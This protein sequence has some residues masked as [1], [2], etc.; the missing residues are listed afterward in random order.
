MQIV[1]FSGIVLSLF[2]LILSTADGR[3]D[4]FYLRFTSNKQKSLILGTSR[5]A[6]G[7][8]P[9]IIDSL[10]GTKMYNYSFTVA[11]SPYGEVYFES[12]KKKIDK[13]SREGVFIITVDPWSI[14]SATVDPNDEKNFRENDKCLDNTKWVN[15]SP[16][17]M[18]LINNFKGKYYSLLEFKGGKT[19]LHPDGWL[20]VTV[21]MSKEAK[22]NRLKGKLKEYKEKY[23]S[24]YKYSSLRF[25][26]LKQIADYLSTYGKVYFVR[27]PI[28]P[29]LMKV[30]EEYMP[31]F[32]DMIKQMEVMGYKY[33]DIT[34]QNGSFVY[35]DGNHLC[36]KSAE[37]VSVLISD[38]INVNH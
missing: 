30:E 20:E 33:L 15:M 23:L 16:N 37:E 32:N 14:S 3:T 29:E 2:F 25:E 38:W 13:S 34:N 10:C 18:Y 22:E 8:I 35:T 21:E 9:S 28:H 1:L 7:I 26:Y 31:D 6:Q 11:H 4:N 36:K 19:V 5:S 27:L 17:F 12:I 24:K